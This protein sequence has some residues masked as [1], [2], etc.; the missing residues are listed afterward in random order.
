MLK[1]FRRFLYN[2]THNIGLIAGVISIGILVGKPIYTTYVE[3]TD[4]KIASG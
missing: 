1:F 4:E 3:S 2:H